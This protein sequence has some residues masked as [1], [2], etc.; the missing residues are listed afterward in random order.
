MPIADARCMLKA[1][2]SINFAPAKH[3]VNPLFREAMQLFTR[4]EFRNQLVLSAALRLSCFVELDT[5]A[6]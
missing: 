3:V 6:A 5:K 4:C 1:D 2:S